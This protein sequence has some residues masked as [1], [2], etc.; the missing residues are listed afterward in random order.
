MQNA[1]SS[2]ACIGRIGMLVSVLACLHRLPCGAQ[3]GDRVQVL[4]PL[5]VR[6]ADPGLLYDGVRLNVALAEVNWKVHFNSGPRE[7]VLTWRYSRT[8]GFVPLTV[9][10]TTRIEFDRRSAELWMTRARALLVS[11][12][13]RAARA[14]G[15]RLT[16]VDRRHLPRRLDERELGAVGIT[17]DGP[18]PVGP[19]ELPIDGHIY[20]RIDVDVKI[21]TGTRKTIQAIHF[22]YVPC[23]WRFYGHV[24][25]GRRQKIR[26]I[27]T[28]AAEFTLED[29]RTGRIWTSHAASWQPIDTRRPRLLFGSDQHPIDFDEPDEALILK[30]IDHEVPNFIAR[31]LPITR[32][33]RVEVVSSKNDDCRRGVR[34]LGAGE[35]AAAREALLAAVADERDDD[36]AWFALG[37]VAEALGNRA[38]AAR[39]Y[40]QAHRHGDAHE[41]PQYRAALLRVRP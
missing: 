37:V 13:Q 26:R 24:H 36:R 23:G 40:E 30:F 35:Y 6:S 4:V 27:I 2:S 25:T 18:R 1:R 3:A 19:Q 16:V 32:T 17:D 29:A 41:R 33:I 22:G 21:E 7:Q 20:A 14:A 12:P 28:F 34:L 8:G 10:S 38:E 39:C 5:T 9:E 31:L 11:R 15:V